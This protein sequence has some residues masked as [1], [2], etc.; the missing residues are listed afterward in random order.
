MAHTCDTQDTHTLQT[1]QYVR[2][3]SCTCVYIRLFICCNH[4]EIILFIISDAQTTYKLYN[5]CRQSICFLIMN[6]RFMQY[7]CISSYIHTYVR[8][9]L[10][11]VTC[12]HICIY[13]AIHILYLY[14][15]SSFQVVCRMEMQQD[16]P[17]TR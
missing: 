17:T 8:M 11:Y 1:Q 7:T 16:K 10:F 3:T 13:R 2:V 4:V 6:N 14:L 12:I 5:P 15:F 9:V